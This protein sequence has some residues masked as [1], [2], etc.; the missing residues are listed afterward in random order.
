MQREVNSRKTLTIY[1]L[2]D[3]GAQMVGDKIGSINSAFEEAI[4]VD[5]P[6]IAASNDAEIQIAIIQFST[7]AS[8][9]TPGT[10]PVNEVIWNDLHASGANDFGDALRLLREDLIHFDSHRNF[11]PIV[12]A[13]SNA[14]VT[15]EYTEVLKQLEQMDCFSNSSRIGIAIGLDADN[16][17]L[18][19]FAG[20]KGTVIAVNDKLKLKELMQ[21]KHRGEFYD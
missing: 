4:T 16:K 2:I 19:S 14:T 6:D 17:A 1:Y 5:L 12:L 20:S 3:T 18:E 13:F 9:L 21:N 15:D 10:V 11:T 8:W 7:G